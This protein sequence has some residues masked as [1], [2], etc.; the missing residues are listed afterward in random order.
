MTD[1]KPFPLPP[2]RY[3]AA[4]KKAIQE[5][6]KEILASGV[7]EASSSPYSSPI[8][9]VPKKDEKFRFCVDFQ[10]LN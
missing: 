4:K 5:Q 9:M 10:R 3:S 7:I 8:V 1:P 2:Y 6:V